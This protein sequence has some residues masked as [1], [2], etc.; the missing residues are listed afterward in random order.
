LPLLAALCG[1]CFADPDL[2]GPAEGPRIVGGEDT[3]IELRPWQVSLQDHALHFC[4]GSILD[5]RWV[6]TAAHCVETPVPNLQVVAGVSRLS[7]NSGQSIRVARVFS[8]PGYHDV[9]RGRDVAL[10]Q[11]ESPLDLSSPR[12]AAISLVTPADEEAGV[13]APGVMGTVS[14]WGRTVDGGFGGPDHLQAVDVPLISNAAASEAYGIPLTDDQ[15]SA[16]YLG[17]GGQDACQGDSGGP[18]TVPGLHGS[19]QLAGIVSWGSTCA[20]PDAPGVYARASAF[21]GWLG[22][23]MATGASCEGI[24]CGEGT[25]VE[26]SQICDGN[27]DCSDGSD[28]GAWCSAGNCNVT[29]WACGDGSCIPRDHE[30]DGV[31]D[32]YDA[33]DEDGHCEAPQGD[34]HCDAGQWACRDGG[35]IPAGYTC[36]GVED[37][38]DASDEGAHCI[39]PAGDGNCAANQF[40]CQDGTCIPAAY[41]C[42]GVEDCPWGS[43][44]AMDCP[45]TGGCLPEEFR[46]N[47]GACVLANFECDGTKDCF[48][49]SD[50]DHCQGE[51]TCT[52]DEWTCHNGQ[53]IAAYYECDGINDCSDLSDEDAH[54]G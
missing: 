25:C 1:G 47:N 31:E 5:A 10:L 54:C 38:Y 39:V 22:V 53:C 20:A 3:P 4:G 29:Q 17:Q 15:L 6:V 52:S 37:C 46:C 16:G 34:G 36:D 23:V 18:L 33:S 50:E 51:W 45:S 13:T 30:C 8:F 26:S 35:C 49:N 2:Q 44:E 11:L 27:A 24:V 14:G 42:D 9:T 32:C 12:V 43:D 7:D 19:P 28:E 40:T 48:D 21:H 41:T